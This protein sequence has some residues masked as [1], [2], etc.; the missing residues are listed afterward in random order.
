M[1]MAPHSFTHDCLHALLA[2]TMITWSGLAGATPVDASSWV[3]PTVAADC[4]CTAAPVARH[5]FDRV[6]I[7]V[8]ENRDYDEVIAD[9]YL[10]QLAKEGASFTNFHGL[11]HPSYPN[12][13]AMVAGKAISTNGDR[14]KNIYEC[15]V[16]DTLKSN[17]LTWKN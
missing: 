8:M 9:S 12:Y 7:I 3:Y 14:Q 1:G 6:L 11:F 4:T 15:T 16:A 2:I 13:L 10:G 17:G 5:W